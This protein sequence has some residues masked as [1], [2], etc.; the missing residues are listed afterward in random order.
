MRNIQAGYD[1]KTENGSWLKGWREDGNIFHSLSGARWG[2]IVS[3]C[4]PN[5]NFQLKQPT[6]EGCT[7]N[8]KSFDTFVDWSREQDGYN[9]S[10]NVRGKSWF[11]QLDKDILVRQNKVYSEDTCL[12]VPHHVNKFVSVK[13][14][15]GMLL[16]IGVSFHKRVGKF[17]AQ[18][19]GISGKVEHLGYMSNP[20]DAHRLWQ[21][22]KYE[23][24]T[25][26]AESFKQSSPTL[27]SALSEWALRLLEDFE[28]HNETKL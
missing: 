12:F 14:R 16:P 28:K 24:G 10:D 27:Y 1:A 17:A 13:R 11:W 5:G 19:M 8:F 25:L 4:K 3:R 18:I 20:E 6:Y 7:N 21:R 2:S 9:F 23:K 22:A 15:T 26:L